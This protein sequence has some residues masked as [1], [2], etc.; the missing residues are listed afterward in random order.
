MWLHKAKK[1]IIRSL[2]WKQLNYKC[3]AGGRS[4]WVSAASWMAMLHCAGF[5]SFRVWGRDFSPA[6]RYANITLR[7]TAGIIRTTPITGG[8]LLNF[9]EL[10]WREILPSLAS[11]PNTQGCLPSSMLCQI[12]NAQSLL[13]FPIAAW[14]AECYDGKGKVLGYCPYYDFTYSIPL[15]EAHETKLGLK[16]HFVK[17]LHK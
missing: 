6:F 2:P 3:K 8:W 17:H 11:P 10:H 15:K 9:E 16:G 12:C 14:K 5:L 13:F 4:E 7:I 1:T